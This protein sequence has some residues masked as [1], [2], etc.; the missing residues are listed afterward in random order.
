M[1]WFKRLFRKNNSSEPVPPIPE[2]DR[3]VEM[4]YDKGLDAYCD[5]VIG[6]IYSHDKSMRYVFLRDEKGI[7]T[8]QFEAI[9][10]FDED[11]WKYI[12][13]Q[14]NAVPASWESY[15]KSLGRSL[16]DNIDDMIKE[17]KSQPEY[18]R[19]FA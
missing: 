5:E 18:K 10:Q 8:Y 1:N 14:D 17:I 7:Y 9:Y 6:V 4:L 12:Y 13:Q 3:I 15:F 11:D 19:Y 16:F 2:W